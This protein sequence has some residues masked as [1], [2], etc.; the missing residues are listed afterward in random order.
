M[1]AKLVAHG[2]TRGEATRQL[3]DALTR[4][5]V[6]GITTNRDFLVR[7]LRHPT[8]SAGEADTSFLDGADVAEL[9]APLVDAEVESLAAAAAALAAQAARRE[10][11]RTL[12]TSPS[13]WRNN[14]SQ[15]QTAMFS[16]QHCEE[17]VIGYRFARDGSLED[18]RI[19]DLAVEAPVL[20]RCSRHEVDLEIGGVRR[21]YLVRD[22][23]VNCDLGQ[24][25]LTEH[26]RFAVP[27]ES[28]AVGSLLSPM[29][30]TVIRVFADVGQSLSAN[31]PVLI[32]EAMKMEH[33]LV[34]S[35]AGTVTELRVTEGE[36][37]EAGVVLAVIEPAGEDS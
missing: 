2:R 3:V 34:S 1:I 22:G 19:N 24:V 36:Q 9:A 25:T 20:H 21:G 13:G 33:E 30:G 23:V 8:F 12:R 4:A 29:P 35:T 15:L 5:E 7:V 18:L 17:L 37:V 11:A 14:P 32:L 28:S 26:P 27:D 6:H 16:G 31:Q 10:T